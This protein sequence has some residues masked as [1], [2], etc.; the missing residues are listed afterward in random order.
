MIKQLALK[1]ILKI[2][3]QKDVQQ[4]INQIQTELPLHYPSAETI[5]YSGKLLNDYIDLAQ[6]MSITDNVDENAPIFISARFRSGST[7][8]WNIFRQLDSLHCYYEPLNERKWFDEVGRGNT[9]DDSH[10]GV[11]DYWKEYQQF[12]SSNIQFETDWTFKRLWLD[13]HSHEPALKNYI[14]SLIEQAPARPVLQFNRVDFRLPWLKKHFPKAKIVHLYRHPR[15][16]W[17]S[18]T[19]NSIEVPLNYNGHDLS[20]YNLFYTAEWA[21]NLSYRFPFLKIS[22]GKHPYYYHYLLWRLSNMLG[23]KH[24]DICIGFESL[25][26]QFDSIIPSVFES[27]GI[28]GYDLK[29]LSALRAQQ[30]GGKWKQYADNNWFTEIESECE[31][32]LNV[33][34]DLSSQR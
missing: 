18:V 12:D 10:Q 27:L 24:A 25:C 28:T 8:L 3:Q 1:I 5:G 14:E 20:R 21:D 11:N 22:Q 23:H 29:T 7:F 31:F 17:I 15:D 13:Q 30:N 6:P 16:Q 4:A 34:F 19:R 33:F 26:H 2:I 9:T 32:I